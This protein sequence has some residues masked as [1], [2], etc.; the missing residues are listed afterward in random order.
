MHDES[1][2]N[3][4]AETGAAAVNLPGLL[5]ILFRGR[6]TVLIVTVLGVLAGLAY[7]FLTRPLYRATAQVRPGIVAYSDQG[8][9]VR[10]WA[11]KDVVRWFRTEMYWQDLREQVQFDHMK[12]A[13]DIIAEYIPMGPQYVQGGDVITLG[14]L[15]SDPLLAVATLDEAIIS[16]N[17]Q[18]SLDSLGSTMYLTLG[19]ARVRMAKIKN[20]IEQVSA[21]VERARLGIAEQKRALTLVDAEDQRLELE[22]ERLASARQWRERAALSTEAE[23]TAARARLEDAEALLSV[24]LEQEEASSATDRSSTD[25]DDSETD[26]LL[27]TVRRQQAGRVADLLLTVNE[28]SRDV[29]RGT[30]EADTLRD[31]IKVLDL[32]A[33]GLRLER[34]VDLVKKKGDIEQ[35]I[36][37]LEIKLARDLPHQRAQLLADWEAEKVRADL[38]SPLER[39]GRITVSEKPVRPR[40]LRA[41]AILTVLAFFSSLFLVLILEYYRRNR[42]AIVASDSGRD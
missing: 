8:G 34:T 6:R 13:P 28:L 2:T 4:P 33:S 3:R 9:P 10:E 1:A 40:K 22:L 26:L 25:T 39:I 18:A 23:V 37:D 32:K 38:V 31:Y 19:G 11:L 36:S 20:D 14:N 24:L 42:A 30:V 16:F 5:N 41:T 7:S 29:Y 35:K 17:R 21:D 27:Q 12:G 15:S